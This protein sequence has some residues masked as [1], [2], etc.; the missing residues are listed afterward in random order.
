MPN[1]DLYYVYNAINKRPVRS[2]LLTPEEASY[3]FLHYACS[4]GKYE[5]AISTFA[6]TYLN[7]SKWH[8][9]M[10]SRIFY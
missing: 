10:N 6:H 5:M 1:L 4:S 8:P 3:Y 7:L 9:R 2:L